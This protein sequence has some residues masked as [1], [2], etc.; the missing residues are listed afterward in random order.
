LRLL[1]RSTVLAGAIAVPC[2]GATFYNDIS[3]D[4]WQNPIEF[5]LSSG[6]NPLSLSLLG[7]GFCPEFI[8]LVVPA[9]LRLTALNLVNFESQ[10]GNESFLG[11]Q[12]GQTLRIS[13]ALFESPPAGTDLTD[14]QIGDL[15]LNSGS[16]GRADLL[17]DLTMESSLGGVSS[18][19]PG[20]YALWF[21]ETGLGAQFDVEFIASPI[22]EPSST[23]LFILTL[24]FLVTSRTRTK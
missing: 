15:R 2:S 17:E 24:A 14:L 6:S 20:E 22:P 9:D 16:V 7:S 11:L 4:D 1:L 18:L 21:N 12:V 5:E 13:P 10:P 3:S 23:S 19:G 8:T